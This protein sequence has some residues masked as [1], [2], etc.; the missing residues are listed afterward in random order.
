MI[1][2]PIIVLTYH[3]NNT[4]TG[5][6]ASD[7]I[8][9]WILI[10]EEYGVTLEYLTGKKN[11]VRVTDA[12]SYV[13]IDILKIQE[14]EALTLL[15]GSENNSFSNIKTYNLNSYFL[16]P[17]RTNKRHGTRIKTKGL[18]LTLLLNTKY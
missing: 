2:Y 1:N 5:L 11:T 6:K 13:D 10:L 18:S 14:E 16:D 15:S 9:C 8:L 7:C 17:Q 12:L 3:N 4:F